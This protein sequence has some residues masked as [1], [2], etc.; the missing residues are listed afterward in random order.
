MDEN[1]YENPKLV[2]KDNCYIKLDNSYIEASCNSFS[3]VVRLPQNL[4]GNDRC[5]TL[6]GNIGIR[7]GRQLNDCDGNTLCD[8]YEKILNNPN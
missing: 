1:I 4:S 5:D 8:I 2:T 6:I 7:L 3:N